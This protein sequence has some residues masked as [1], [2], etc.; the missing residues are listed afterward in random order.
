MQNT[1]LSRKPHQPKPGQVFL[2][3]L[4]LARARVH[5]AC[6]PARHALAMMIAGEMAGPVFWVG[7]QWDPAR[8]HGPG[9]VRFADPGRFTFIHARRPE[10]ILW[11][12]EEVLRAGIIPLVVGDLA[13]PPGLT[14]VRR[15]HLAGETGA[16]EGRVTPLGLILTPEGGGAGVESRWHMAPD[17][18]PAHSTWKLTRQ[19]A[20]QDPPQSWDVRAQGKGFSLAPPAK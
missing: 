16:R 13:A 14:P 1:L 18:G 19:R 5:E 2:E 3:H 20:R 10:D 8:L 7:A 17:H 11:T 6:G 9:M 12:I 4:V 15:M